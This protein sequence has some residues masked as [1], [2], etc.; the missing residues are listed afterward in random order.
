[1]KS[2]ILEKDWSKT[3]RSKFYLDYFDKNLSEIL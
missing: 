1:M 3:Q 2:N